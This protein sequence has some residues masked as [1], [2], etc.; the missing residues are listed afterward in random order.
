MTGNLIPRI[1]ECQGRQKPKFVGPRTWFALFFVVIPFV[2]LHQEAAAFFVENSAETHQISVSKNIIVTKAA[3]QEEI[4]RLVPN[5]INLLI[6]QASFQISSR[7][8]GIPIGTNE[9]AGRIPLC[10]LRFPYRNREIASAAGSE[11]GFESHQGGRR[12]AVICKTKP[13]P[14]SDREYGLVYG[15]IDRD[16]GIENFQPY[17]GY[18]QFSQRPFSDLGGASG[19]EPKK[20]GRDSQASGEESHT[21]SPQS[22]WLGPSLS[23]DFKS[24]FNYGAVGGV[25]WLFF[26][27]GLA[28]V[29]DG[30]LL[31]LLSP[32]SVI[33]AYILAFG[34]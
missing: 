1:V 9:N 13:N 29:Q 16:A 18:L 30:R 19:A 12:S 10:E 15:E 33:T 17:K 5:G 3:D 21:K 28:R 34:P 23:P 4:S 20:T 32:L 27:W 2:A 14:F 24:A 7:R 31:I 25:G 8:R 11:V 6:T 26:F 22:F